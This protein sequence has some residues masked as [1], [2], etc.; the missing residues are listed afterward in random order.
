VAT[1]VGAVRPEI[2]V[3]KLYR[4][5]MSAM[6]MQAMMIAPNEIPNMAT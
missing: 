1:R 5:K 4:E 2:F 3:L 6:R